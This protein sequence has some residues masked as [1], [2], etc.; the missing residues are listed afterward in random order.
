MTKKSEK[1]EKNFRSS[2]LSSDQLKTRLIK[3]C[4]GLVYVSET[5]EPVE[6]FDI[7]STGKT[8]VEPIAAMHKGEELELRSFDELFS[9]LTLIREHY[10]ERQ[11]RRA[12]KFLDL[13]KLIEENL[14]DPAVL[15]FGRI[16]ISIYVVGRSDDRIIGV[17]TKAIET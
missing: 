12:K 2:R 1:N 10:G 5:D 14:A 17:K 9:R 16:R 13:R 8:I 7:Q 15:R 6:V 3:A 4:Q 11:I